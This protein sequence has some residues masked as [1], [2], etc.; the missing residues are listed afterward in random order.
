MGENE[1]A[2]EARLSS[3]VYSLAP[4]KQNMVKMI[5]EG[6][7]GRWRARAGEKGRRHPVYLLSSFRGSVRGTMGR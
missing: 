3:S 2:M 1:E 5:K 6:G 4:E 7:K